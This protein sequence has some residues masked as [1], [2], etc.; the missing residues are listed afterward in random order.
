MKPF[1]EDKL[2]LS[3]DIIKGAFTKYI[4]FYMMYHKDHKK[5]SRVKK[6]RA[7]NA[8]CVYTVHEKYIFS[9]RSL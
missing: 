7:V 8:R 6:C 3:F 2:K 1:R 5:K 4:F 9:E